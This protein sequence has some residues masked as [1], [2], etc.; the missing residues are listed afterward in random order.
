MG[1]TYHRGRKPGAAAVAGVLALAT[2]VWLVVRWRPF[3]V[4]VRGESMTPTLW[5][6]DQALAVPSRRPALGHV[7]VV[8]H[9][10]R[11]GLEIVKRVTGA[12]GDLAPD[13]RIL[14]A[15]EFWVAG[16]NP[17]RSTDSRQHGTVRR[18]Q[19]KA[20][21]RVVYWPPSRRGLVSSR[22]PSVRA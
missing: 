17:A 21:I 6:G 20:R 8:E 11:A 16:D 22:P 4:E 13:G 12:P 18:E 1:E 3:P 9:P 15:D 7:V 5:P 14:G 2:A 19:I 10:T